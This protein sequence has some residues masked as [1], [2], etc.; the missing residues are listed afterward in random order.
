[1]VKK[2]WGRGSK[3]VMSKKEGGTQTKEREK[4]V[5]GRG[6]E[7]NNH[8]KKEQTGGNPELEERAKHYKNAAEKEG[9]EGCNN[10]TKVW[11]ID[12][13]GTPRSPFG[14]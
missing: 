14:R 1:M 4:R 9:R 3:R 11:R 5:G 12:R 7:N 8:S 2:N 13:K 6:H 10:P